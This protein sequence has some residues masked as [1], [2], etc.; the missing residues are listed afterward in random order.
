MR[1]E[2]SS[3]RWLKRTLTKLAG[4]QPSSSSIWPHHQSLL[5]ASRTLMTSPA[6]K[7][8]SLSAIVTWSHTASALTTEPPLINCRKT[9]WAWWRS[10]HA[11]THTT[12]L[13][14]TTIGYTS[15][16][17]QKTSDSCHRLSQCWCSSKHRERESPLNSSPAPVPYRDSF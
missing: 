1:W 12:C 15:A 17:G 6:L 11:V 4:N 10:G 16:I 8:S 13:K 5:E 9:R 7:A 14:H 2:S 3:K